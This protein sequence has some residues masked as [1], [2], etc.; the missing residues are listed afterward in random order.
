M[1]NS[2]ASAN[3]FHTEID[4]NGVKCVFYLDHSP[5]VRWDGRG[6][7]PLTIDQVTAIFDEWAK[8]HYDDDSESH[9]ISYKL[10]SVAPEGHRA[11][12]WIYKI[13][14]INLDPDAP[15]N[16]ISRYIVV[17]MDGKVIER[18]CDAL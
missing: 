4:H 15:P 8:T 5:A 11:S 10:W 6:A 16:L 3:A 12:S 7:P 2:C 17:T 1:P 18:I 14:Y 9:I 13:E